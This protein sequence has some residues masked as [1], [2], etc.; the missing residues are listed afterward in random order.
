MQEP[1]AKQ[2]RKRKPRPRKRF[3][4]AERKQEPTDSTADVHGE[5]VRSEKES[6]LD[7]SHLMPQE[8]SAKRA[9]HQK[10]EPNQKKSVSVDQSEKGEG[11]SLKPRNRQP[12]WFL[13]VPTPNQRIHHV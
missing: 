12:T 8:P 6:A 5:S 4:N 13:A 2:T 9:K 7:K 11:S 3:Q 10:P 1:S